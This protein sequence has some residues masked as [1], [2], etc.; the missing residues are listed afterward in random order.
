MAAKKRLLILAA[1]V[2]PLVGIMLV[3]KALGQPGRP[4]GPPGG[5]PKPPGVP[6]GPPGIPKPPGGVQPGPKPWA[7]PQTE[8]VWKCSRCS[9]ELSRGGSRPAVDRC[10]GCGAVILNGPSGGRVGDGP[11]KPIAPPPAPQPAPQGPGGGVAPQPA[12]A[13]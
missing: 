12:P 13:E 9:A 1:V 2:L 8:T 7:P 11:G 5:F 10:P 3:G 6:G 4:G